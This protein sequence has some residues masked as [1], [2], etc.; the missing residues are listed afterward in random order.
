[1]KARPNLYSTGALTIGAFAVGLLVWR[2]GLAVCDERFE[3]DGAAAAVCKGVDSRLWPVAAVA[4][5]IA[6]IGG[7]IYGRRRNAP[8]KVFAVVLVL[9][10][11]AGAVF[12]VIA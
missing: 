1:M 6:V 11:A 9:A 4:P 2:F 3:L 5:P 7:A 8:T 12:A 10:I